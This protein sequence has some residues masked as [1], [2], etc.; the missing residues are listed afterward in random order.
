M[1]HRKRGRKLKRGKSQNKAL[2]KALAESLILHEKIKTT[3]TR[4]K[5]LRSFVERLL[6][7]AKKQDLSSRRYVARILSKDA[8][9]KLF[10]DISQRYKERAGGYTRVIKL[11]FRSGND[12]A[13]ISQIEFVE[14][15]HEEK[16]QQ[17][18][19]KKR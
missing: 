1:K 5:E 9:K 3:S 12:K 14:S 18:G 15:K 8:T 6:T 17:T 13:D 2:L 16:I 11:G 7:F 19:N 10:N 4:A